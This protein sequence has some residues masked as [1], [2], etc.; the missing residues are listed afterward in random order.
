MRAI[1][2]GAAAGE[3]DAIAWRSTST[4]TG[5]AASIASMTAALGGLDAI[6]F[7]GG[8]GERAP[9]VRAMA[10]DGLGFLGIALD[11]VRERGAWVRRPRD[12][13]AAAPRF[14]RS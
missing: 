12:R 9:A 2:A 3:R 4:S 7:T 8:V 11:A 14:G 1:L 10:A 5:S 6:V 13:R